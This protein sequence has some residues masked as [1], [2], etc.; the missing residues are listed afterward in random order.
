ME[1]FP[2]SQ[3]KT[4]I[5]DFSIKCRRILGGGRIRGARFPHCRSLLS[6]DAISGHFLRKPEEMMNGFLSRAARQGAAHDI[7][8]DLNPSFWFVMLFGLSG[9]SLVWVWCEG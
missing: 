3:S 7:V 8:E 6:A 4:R 9:S 2:A 5:C 1:N